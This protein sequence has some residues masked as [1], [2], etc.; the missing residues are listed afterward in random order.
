ML[1]R[2][3][4]STIDALKIIADAV[5]RIS[6]KA[7]QN[8]EWAVLLTLDIKNA[9]N[10]AP[11]TGTGSGTSMIAYANDLAVGKAV[12]N[13]KGE[14]RNDRLGTG[15]A[16]DGNGNSCGKTWV[17][18]HGSETGR[19]GN[20]EPRHCELHGREASNF[21][22][23]LKR[24]TPNIKGPSSVKR[25]M[26]ATTVTST[27]LY[28]TPTYAGRSNGIPIRDGPALTGY[29]VFGQ[30]LHRIAKAE[31]SN[32]WYC[33][34]GYT[35]GRMLFVC[36]RWTAL[37]VRA[38]VECTCLVEESNMAELLQ[39]GEEQKESVK[40]MFRGVIRTKCDVK[41]RRTTNLTIG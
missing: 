23:K 12:D 14:A 21:I 17:Q 13:D 18:N 37:R 1:L 11:W 34:Y 8:R 24:I 5:S 6:E 28:A 2:R 20:S 32:F 4:R 16:Q 26:L 19:S 30:Y 3:G 40:R 36:P 39:G 10:L 15:D 41:S 9:F 38:N 29:G 35:L 7:Y 33:E 31:N 22:K 27:I 25:R